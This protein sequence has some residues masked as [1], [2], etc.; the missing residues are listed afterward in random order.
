MSGL[1]NKS[2][3][4]QQLHLLEMSTHKKRDPCVCSDSHT[5]ARTLYFLG[6]EKPNICPPGDSCGHSRASSHAEQVLAP[7]MPRGT[8]KGI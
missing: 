5:A 7:D 4:S 2:H 3:R 6:V 1:E 8:H